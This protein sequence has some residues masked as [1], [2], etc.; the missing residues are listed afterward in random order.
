M[1]NS[2]FIAI[3]GLD[4]SGK[5]TQI[6][7]LKD[8]LADNGIV[9]RFIHFPRTEEGV[10]GDLIARFLRGEFGDAKTVHPQ[11]VAL[12]F[13]LDRLAAAGQIKEWLAQG[14]YVLVDRYV[15]SN[16]A[17]QCAKLSEAAERL[18]L[19]DWIFN[20]EFEHNQIPKP[21]LSIFLDVPFEFTTKALSDR[22]KADDRNYL[23]GQEDVHEKDLGLQQAVLVEYKRLL[24]SQTDIKA[25][26]CFDKEGKMRPVAA[27]QQDI[28]GLL[29]LN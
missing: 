26:Q 1:G 13:A 24:V 2:K 17:F 12:L 19:T 5:S 22:R 9:T 14:D 23:K 6:A 25:I 18:R 4:G 7:L 16:V 27:I 8:R 29:G 28:R 15:L 3:E 10:Y 11:M 21:D 20:F